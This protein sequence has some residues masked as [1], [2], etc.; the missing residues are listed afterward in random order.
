MKHGDTMK[1]LLVDDENLIRIG[2]KTFINKIGPHQVLE[3]SNGED[4]IELIR[5]HNP[6]IVFTDI[7]MPVMNGVELIKKAKAF[8]FQTTFIVLSCFDDYDYVRESLKYGAY[9][10]ILK[11]KIDVNEISK[12]L[13]S[14][15][16]K[17]SSISSGI[18][19]NTNRKAIL[20][21][22]LKGEEF[23]EEYIAESIESNGLRLSHKKAVLAIMEINRNKNAITAEKNDSIFNL[24]VINL[25]DDIM[26]RYG[27]GEI[28]HYKEDL[29]FLA[30]TNNYPSQA[31][32]NEE[33]KGILNSV[34]NAMKKYLGAFCRFAVITKQINME[35]MQYALIR[36]NKLYDRMFFLPEKFIIDENTPPP[37]ASDI[38]QSLQQLFEIY[39]DKVLSSPQP[40]L[41]DTLDQLFSDIVNKS[42]YDKDKVKLFFKSFI[43]RYVTDYRRKYLFDLNAF[44]EY[45]LKCRE[46]EAC[47]TISRLKKIVKEMLGTMAGCEKDSSVINPVISKI[48]GYMRENYKLELTLEKVSGLFKFNS[49]YLSRL[50][51]EQTGK[52]FIEY[53]IMIRVEAAVR[54]L[55]S[56]DMTI[57]EISESCGF[58][59]SQYF[60][61]VFRKHTG[62]APLDFRRNHIPI[63]ESNQ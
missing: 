24:S 30:F 54:L 27:N 49:C 40:L 58:N 39:A 62:L 8:G 20:S 44:H 33:M 36:L 4:A 57:K 28:V 32:G 5:S 47:K 13:A 7:K 1:I 15:K 52:N 11:H 41:G 50:F 23:S 38:G 17:N 46:I 34:Q 21:S 2:I 25:V 61:T 6:D 60:S 42:D 9:D 63:R 43:Y 37:R 16:D 45:E 35:K 26:A 3:C 53:L 51:K 48:I 59:N 19:E 10:Y 12:L 22:M 55:G 31:A 14:V 18:Q 29:F 56:T